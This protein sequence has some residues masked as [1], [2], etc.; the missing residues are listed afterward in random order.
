[1][2]TTTEEEWHGEECEVG[3]VDM[4]TKCYRCQ[5]YGHLARDCGTKPE[6]GKG[7]GGG[8]PGKAQPKGQGKGGY[9]GWYGKG[10]GKGSKGDGKGKGYMGA[11]W[12]CGQVGHKALECTAKV[13]AVDGEE[14]FEEVS[15]G[16]VWMIGSVDAEWE[17]VGK[18]KMKNKRGSPKKHPVALNN[19]FEELSAD[20]EVMINAIEA[21]GKKLTRP[22]GMMFNVADVAKPLASAVKVCEAG[23]RIIMD[24]EP[25]KSYVENIL[26]GE[27]MLL[28]RDK[29]TFVFEVEYTDDGEMGNITLDSGAGVSV[30]PRKMKENLKTLPKK[31]GLSMVAANGTKIENYGQKL[32]TFKGV[33]P[34]FSGGA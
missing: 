18:E 29:G 6:K 24:P 14:G 19:R 22:S 32:I 4:N 31:K 9:D 23:N 25:G 10:G 1:M 11:C 16:G 34:L 13:N 33:Q 27:R 2:E 7:K 17:D 12:K 21:E 28:K 26:T 3:A 5:G 8:N 15:V 30:W 20:E